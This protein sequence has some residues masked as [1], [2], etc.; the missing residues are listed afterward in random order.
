MDMNSVIKPNFN[1]L[2][3]A[4]KQ[5]CDKITHGSHNCV[6][7]MLNRFKKT[8]KRI[9]VANRLETWTRSVAVVSE[10]RTFGYP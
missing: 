4:L 7:K 2:E 5:L 8:Q 6:Q 10:T 1:E 3:R 9:G